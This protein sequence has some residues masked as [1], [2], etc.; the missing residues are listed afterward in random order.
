MQGGEEFLTYL[1]ACGVP[2]WPFGSTGHGSSEEAKRGG[3][4]GTE[5]EV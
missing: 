1:H 2:V 5:E 3:E 4:R